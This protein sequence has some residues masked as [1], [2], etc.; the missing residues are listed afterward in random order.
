MGDASAKVTA[1]LQTLDKALA[2]TLPAFLAL[3]DVPVGDLQ[4]EAL[5]PPATPP[6]H[7][8]RGQTP[9]LAGEPGA[10]RAVAVRGS[11][12]D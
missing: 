6:R 7:P 11:T 3:L 10:A 2:P 4:W 5:D 1:H 9:A 12:L 8:E